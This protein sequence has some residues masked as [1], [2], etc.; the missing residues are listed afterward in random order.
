MLLVCSLSLT[1][2]AGSLLGFDPL[3]SVPTVSSP[4]PDRSPPA[5][6]AFVG[7]LGFMVT[8]AGPLGTEASNSNLA[9]E[10]YMGIRSLSMIRE[11]KACYNVR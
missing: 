11:R 9:S 2:W 10:L 4:A 6:A 8:M 3:R 5:S 7:S 1:L